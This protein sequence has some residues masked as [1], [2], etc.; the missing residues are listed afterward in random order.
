VADDAALA[1]RLAAYLDAPASRL[2]DSALPRGFVPG[3]E[4]FEARLAGILP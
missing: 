1:A 3:A 4:E 2:V